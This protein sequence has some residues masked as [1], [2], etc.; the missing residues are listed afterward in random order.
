MV[1]ANATEIWRGEC[2]K[3][4]VVPVLTLAAVVAFCQFYVWIHHVDAVSR[5]RRVHQQQGVLC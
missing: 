4:W 1:C 2:D 5:P 3:L